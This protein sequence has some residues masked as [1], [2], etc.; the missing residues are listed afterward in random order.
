MVRGKRQ[1]DL[2]HQ[3][4]V[5]KVVDD[6][7]AVEE[8]HGCCQPVPVEALGRV[9]G[10][11]A[12]RDVCDGDDLF[13][14]DDLDGCDDE[15]HVDMAHEE[16]GEED[17]HHDESPERPRPEV[18]LFLLVLGLLLVRRRGFLQRPPTSSSATGSH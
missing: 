17:G 4:Y 13:E 12:A 9:D 1:Q 2:I 10:S 5:L 7:F 16:R 6:A 11:R 18:G 3:Y 15:D 14:G 8:V